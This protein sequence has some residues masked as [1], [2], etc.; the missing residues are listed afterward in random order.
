MS[1]SRALA[2]VVALVAGGLD[3]VIRALWWSPGAWV[4]PV[5]GGRFCAVV[6]VTA[7]AIQGWLQRST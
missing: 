1:E 5:C 6:K 7:G 3:V 4:A 2:E